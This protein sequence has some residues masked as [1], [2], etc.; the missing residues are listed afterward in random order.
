MAQWGVDRWADDVPVPAFGP[1]MVWRRR[2]AELDQSGRRGLTGTQWGG[3][4]FDVSARHWPD[5]K[6][7]DSC[8]GRRTDIS[9]FR[10]PN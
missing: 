9:G 1:R 2:A 10:G 7:N 3:M 6:F 4:S 5:L 8:V